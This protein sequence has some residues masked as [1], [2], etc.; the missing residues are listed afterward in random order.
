MRRTKVRSIYSSVQAVYF[1]FTNSSRCRKKVEEEKKKSNI[2]VSSAS[3]FFPLSRSSVD[4]VAISFF[5]TRI[6]K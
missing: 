1:C 6:E 3:P 5:D 2:I 4:S